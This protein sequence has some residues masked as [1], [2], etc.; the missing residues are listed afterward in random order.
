MRHTPVSPVYTLGSN[1][2]QRAD[3]RELARRLVRPPHRAR[4][5]LTEIFRATGR[6]VADPETRVLPDRHF[7]AR[8]FTPAS[9]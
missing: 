5:R 3:H 9:P 4:D 1:P 7:L 8:A 6:Q 2:A